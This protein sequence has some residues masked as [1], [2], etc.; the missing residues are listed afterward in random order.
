MRSLLLHSFAILYMSIECKCY[1]ILKNHIVA[2]KKI[3]QLLNWINLVMTSYVYS[4]FGAATF[5]NKKIKI[6]W[7][8]KQNLFF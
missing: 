7:Y 2:I 4:L 5:K 1:R 6:M 3:F 8:H